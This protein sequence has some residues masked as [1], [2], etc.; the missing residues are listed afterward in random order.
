M[1]ALSKEEIQ[2]LLEEVAQ[3]EQD[4][5]LGFFSKPVRISHQGEELMLKTYAPLKSAELSR[6]IISHHDKYV[7]ALRSTGVKVPDTQITSMNSPKGEQLL[8]IQRAFPSE[9]LLRTQ[10]IEAQSLEEVLSLIEL[11]FRDTLKYWVNRPEQAIGFHP[12]LRNYSNLDEELY[13]FDTFPPMLVEQR[14]LNKL[15]RQMSPYGGGLLKRFLPLNLLN[16]VSDEYYQLD[17]MFSGIVGSTCRLHPNYA[18]DILRF[19][20]EFLS[21]YSQ[22]KPEERESILQKLKAPPKLPKIWVLIRKW[23]GNEGAPNLEK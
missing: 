20:K 12:T 9:A 7:D 17:K 5:N 2:K 21:G 13:Y 11:I 16:R 15:I 6:E 8:I 3:R 22:L 10:V 4:S 1:L 23:S 19:A 18:E 14:E